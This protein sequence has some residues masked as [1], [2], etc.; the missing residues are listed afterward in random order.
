MIGE[1]KCAYNGS[2]GV[3]SAIYGCRCSIRLFS[4][5]AEEKCCEALGALGSSRLN[6]T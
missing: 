3:L 5:V 6:E 1:L 4:E 2:F